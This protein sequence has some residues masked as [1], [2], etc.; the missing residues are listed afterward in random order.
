[1]KLIMKTDNGEHHIIRDSINN[2]SLYQND[3]TICVNSRTK[4]HPTNYRQL[5]LKDSK[6]YF[7]KKQLRAFFDTFLKLLDSMIESLSKT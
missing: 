4:N 2:E 6:L 5:V 1:M 7:N 3:L